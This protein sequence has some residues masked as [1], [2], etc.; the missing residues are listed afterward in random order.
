MSLPGGLVETSPKSERGGS[1]HR[2]TGV[3]R[4]RSHNKKKGDADLH[5]GLG[6]TECM[7]PLEAPGLS[8][9]ASGV[10][11]EEI[12]VQ[13]LDRTQSN[14]END[15]TVKPMEVN[16]MSSASD[17]TLSRKVRDSRTDSLSSKS[18][19]FTRKRN[20]NIKNAMKRISVNFDKNRKDSASSVVIDS[21]SLEDFVPAGDLQHTTS[22][23]GSV[24]STVNKE[25]RVNPS[26]APSNLVESIDSKRKCARRGSNAG[27]RLSHTPTRAVN[28]I[29]PSTA[30][31]LAM[32][33]TDTKQNEDMPEF[34]PI[35]AVADGYKVRAT[36]LEAK[37]LPAWPSGHKP[38]V[39]V[40][41][42]SNLDGKNYEKKIKT[43]H[44]GESSS[45]GSGSSTVPKWNE[46][47]EFDHVRDINDNMTF[48]V[49][50]TTSAAGVVVD[51]KIGQISFPVR[52]VPKVDAVPEDSEIDQIARGPAIVAHEKNNTIDAA[53]LRMVRPD[54]KTPVKLWLK[55]TKPGTLPMRLKTKG[56]KEGW[57]CVVLCLIPAPMDD[58]SGPN[59]CGE[60]EVQN[61]VVYN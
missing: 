1:F 48:K 12:E 22:N 36:I 5:N 3:F 29:A 13:S 55:L 53:S 37:D 38:R 32:T 33:M 54:S 46:T 56:Y 50:V 51:H 58:D 16:Y 14:A 17:D 24:S 25:S 10:L 43:K 26:I 57:I 23:T 18:P 15:I 27:A 11:E 2:A 31:S 44:V 4:R 30:A 9:I 47:V 19:N 35:W 28:L 34:T 52:F 61:T 49:Y 42:S 60:D 39:S 40:S 21:S 6:T 7:G 20:K 8:R 45:H 59:L 41:V